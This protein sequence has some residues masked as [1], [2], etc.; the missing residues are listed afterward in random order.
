MKKWVGMTYSADGGYK[1]HVRERLIRASIEFGRQRSMFCNRRLGRPIKVSGYKGAVLINATFGCETIVLSPWT[2]KKYE[3]FNARCTAV[4]SHRTFAAEKSKPSFDVIKWIHWRRARWLGGA[5][6]GEKGHLILNAVQWGFQH[7]VRGDVFSDLPQAMKTTF[8]ALRQNALNI[9]FWSDYCDDI[10]PEK[11]TVYDKDG[12]ARRRRSP[13][14]ANRSN[15]RALQRETLRRQLI[16]TAV[17]R[18]P[19]P[20][21]VPQDEVHVY[22]DGAATLRRGH[23]G[24]GSGV[25]FGDKSNFN[26]SAIPP[27]KQ[28]NN[29][30]E[31]TAI[32]LAVRKAMAWPKEFR[33]LVV[34]SDSRL[35]VDGINKWLPLWEAD[36]WTRNGNRLENADLWR[37]MKRVLSALEKANLEVEFRYVPAHVGVY[38]NERADR[39]AKAAARRAHIA[40]SRT[41]EQREEQLLDALADSIV[42]AIAN[43]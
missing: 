30:A 4:I 21:D 11:W 28:T 19:A 35:C 26:I 1:D 25:W 2:I 43:R 12:G 22:T 18:R 41:V 42:A 37:V 39:L 23:W 14:Q 7:Q 20:D 38:G 36:G 5:L 24:A 32:I 13:R 16:G 8:R 31:L 40:A 27:G 33:L 10:K 29:R 17:T 6:R 34:H 15:E 3:D 9:K